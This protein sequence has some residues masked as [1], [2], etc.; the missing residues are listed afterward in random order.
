MKTLTP[1]EMKLFYA[2][3]PHLAGAAYRQRLAHLY[4]NCQSVSLC[5]RSNRKDAYPVRR[6][7][8]KD[9]T[10]QKCLVEFRKRQEQYRCAIWQMT[11]WGN[12]YRRHR[13]LHRE[14]DPTQAAHAADESVKRAERER[15]KV[16]LDKPGEIDY[17]GVV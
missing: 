14:W 13:R 1:D 17:T 9:S 3:G 12:A 15:A 2:H 10:C 8:R 16:T 5:G 6:F 4:F 7:R 11:T